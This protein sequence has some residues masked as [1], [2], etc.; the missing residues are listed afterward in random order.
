MEVAFQEAEGDVGEAVVVHLAN[1]KGGLVIPTKEIDSSMEHRMVVHTVVMA[2]APT[3][4]TTE[5]DSNHGAELLPSAMADLRTYVQ[6][7]L[8]YFTLLI[9]AD[10]CFSCSRLQCKLL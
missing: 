9:L 6:S 3:T 1:H 7:T 2:Q 10:Q 4:S 8:L 5:M